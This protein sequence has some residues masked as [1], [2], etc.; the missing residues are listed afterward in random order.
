MKALL[1]GRVLLLGVTLGCAG[2][3]LDPAPS[4]ESKPGAVEAS[5]VEGEPCDVRAVF[6]T[7]C[8]SCHAQPSYA[9]TYQHAP[10][11]TFSR[12]ELEAKDETGSTLAER[13]ALRLNDTQ[14]P[15][16]PLVY[17]ARPMDDERALVTAW[18]AAGMPAGSCGK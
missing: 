16:P 12:A 10:T 5:A 4:T 14:D 2:E 18:I 15:M 3:A 17:I 13:V 1:R 6:D 8:T 11:V 7:Y 9:Y